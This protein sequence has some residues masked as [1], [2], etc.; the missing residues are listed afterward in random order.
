[1]ILSTTN[2]QLPTTSHRIHKA[3]LHLVE[4]Q[5]TKS[6]DDKHENKTISQ[7]AP[8]DELASTQGPMLEGL[9][10]GGH[11]VEAH[12]GG[13][14]H[15]HH[16]LAGHLAQRIDDRRSIHPQLN[17]EREKDLQVAVLGRHRR[18]DDA[19]AQGQSCH[20]HHQQGEE[21]EIPVGTWCLPDDGVININDDEQAELDA[22]A[23]Q[24]ARDVRQRHDEPREIHLA[25]DARMADER[26]GRA[27]QAVGEILPHAHAAK[28]KQGLRDA[29]GG[30]ARDA[31]KHHHVHD[32]RQ[33][34][35]D[36]P[37]QRAKDGLLVGH[38]DVAL[39]K[40]RVEVAIVPYFL[41]VHLK[42]PVS[43]LDDGGPFLVFLFLLCHLLM[44]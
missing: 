32:D 6:E 38:R 43:R 30:D 11:G 17:D 19:E 37:P 40:H 36:E 18:D 16:L 35:L 14:V 22:E 2:P 31:A 13:K 41:Q 29:V 23:H 1:M 25:E 27:V 26:V 21:Q 4:N 33:G 3:L 39:H 24:V 10:D 15:A 20:H 34:G 12:D 44:L 7:P 8:A 5:D 28:V 42:K 9:D